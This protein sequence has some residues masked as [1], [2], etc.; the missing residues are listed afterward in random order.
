MSVDISPLNVFFFLNLLMLVGQIALAYFYWT[1]LRNRMNQTMATN[2]SLISAVTS[3]VST[4]QKN[5]DSNKIT[6]AIANAQK[7]EAEF[8]E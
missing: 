7:E 1:V 2:E 4:L 5:I 6:Q 3:L 8:S